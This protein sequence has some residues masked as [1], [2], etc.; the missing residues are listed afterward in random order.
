[1]IDLKELHDKM[2]ELLPDQRGSVCVRLL[3]TGVIFEWHIFCN[4]RSFQFNH[5]LNYCDMED[6]TELAFTM[7]AVLDLARTEIA[8]FVEAQTDG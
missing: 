3:S 8:L 2:S 5:G 4:G 1:M 7:A 6:S